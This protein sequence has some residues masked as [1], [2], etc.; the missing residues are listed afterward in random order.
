[1]A[2]TRKQG[3]V[4]LLLS[5]EKGESESG[6]PITSTITVGKIN[7]AATDDKLY[8]AGT[9]IMSLQTFPASMIQRRDYQQLIS[10]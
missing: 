7:P 5:V 6:N 10:E 9:G 4:A 1:M 3:A 2:V 8:T